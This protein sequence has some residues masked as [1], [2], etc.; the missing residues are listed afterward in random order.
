M[1]DQNSDW[2]QVEDPVAVAFLADP[3]SV[4]LLTPFFQGQKSIS[5]AAAEGGAAFSRMYYVTVKALRLG[6]LEVAS[7][8]KRKGKA[9][10]RYRCAAR[11]FFVPHRF[12]KES[13]R[14]SRLAREN[15]LL[16]LKLDAAAHS[17]PYEKQVHEGEWGF[18][19]TFDPEKGIGSFMNST[20]HRFKNVE[21]YHAY[22]LSE[23]ATAYLDVFVEQLVLSDKDAKAF[24]RDLN[25][26]YLTYLKLGNRGE[27]QGSNYFAR[28][29]LAQLPDG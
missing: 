2:L 4:S 20:Q 16:P 3:K 19:T 21:D 7:V 6:L 8:Q 9:I 5:E 23:N 26:L 22:L 10:K 25:R 11:A 13:L 29:F 14:D 17:S 15:R 24:Q 27:S 18:L 12:M 28:I 1:S